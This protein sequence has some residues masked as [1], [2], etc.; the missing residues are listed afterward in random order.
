MANEMN[1]MSEKESRD[2][3]ESMKHEFSERLAIEEAND[4]IGVGNSTTKASDG[5]AIK[6]RNGSLIKTSTR[7]AKSSMESRLMNTEY[8]GI[9]GSHGSWRNV[10]Q[11]TPEM[12]GPAGFYDPDGSMAKILDAAESESGVKNDFDDI[13]KG[14]VEDSHG[15]EESFSDASYGSV[16]DYSDDESASPVE[17]KEEK[18][19]LEYDLEDLEAVLPGMPRSRL[20]KVREAFRSTLSYPS[21]IQLV[22][23]LRENMPDHLNNAWLKRKNILNAYFCVQKAKEDNLIDRHMIN[24]MLQVV[25]SAGKVGRALAIHEEQFKGYGIEPN[26]YSDRLVL[27]MLVKN[28]RLSRALEFKQKIEADGRNMDLAS[29]GSL[30]E[31][32]AKREQVGSA[33]MMLRECVAVH[34]APPKEGDM[35]FLRLICRQQDI[36]DETGLVELAG[37]DPLEWLRHG[38]SNHKRESSKKGRRGV[39]E[40]RNAAIRI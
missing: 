31:Y 30:V 6:N 26:E 14:I 23:I 10:L 20:L 1:G 22:P 12:G 39:Q 40:A 32:Y 36:L 21:M 15:D 13:M 37:P 2:I 28:Q 9:D 5:V 16:G 17:V 7:D 8:S 25:T 24:G 19:S 29:Y 34:G 3:Y 35:K 38:E 4:L 11:M 27:Q 33:V 18:S